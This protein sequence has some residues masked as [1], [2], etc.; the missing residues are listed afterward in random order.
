MLLSFST[1]A[2][3]KK[4]SDLKYDNL[5]Y[6]SFLDF[7]REL[8]NE[9]YYKVQEAL[10]SLVDPGPP[11]EANLKLEL[12]FSTGI[13]DCETKY[14]YA[15]HTARSHAQDLALVKCIDS[16]ADRCR[17]LYCTTINIFETVKSKK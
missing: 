8:D 10:N 9:T 4:C 2:E 12:C 11:G 3:G 16:G 14:F 7:S 5:Q 1:S 13:L 17:N 6:D 15:F